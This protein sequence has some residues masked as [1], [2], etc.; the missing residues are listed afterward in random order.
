MSKAAVPLF[1][2]VIPTYNRAMR[3]ARTIDTVLAQS[4]ANFELLI[5]DD[6]S[7]DGTAE[8]VE[9]YRDSRIRYDWAPNS[10][11]PATPRN[12]GIDLAKGDWV[13][14]LDADDLWYPKKLEA[15]AEV[16]T[17]APEITAIC[18]N[19]YRKNDVTGERRLL[20]HGPYEEDFYRVML[21]QGNRVSTSAVVVRREFLNRNELRFNT[22]E[23]YAIVEDYDLWLRI[24]LTSGRFF[25]IE[26]PLGEYIIE[27]DN[28]TSNFKRYQHNRTCLLRDHVM[29]VQSFEPNR[30][31]LWR[32]MKV[33]LAI[34]NSK[35]IV[36][37]HGLIPAAKVVLCAAL[38]SPLSLAYYFFWW[39]RR[40]I[41]NIRIA[42]VVGV[43]GE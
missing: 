5:M 13:A 14:F 12:R 28:L 39:L 43:K 42:S 1:S 25:F 31:K 10:G 38:N 37:T 22:T 7:T 41:R 19:E 23:E 34:Q 4:F 35:Q 21:L 9:S 40:R 3:L 11:G 2:V 30:E 6:G 29:N 32:M 33:R 18:H 26:D 15:V 24:A 20:C 27:N 8:M 17:H 36:R 16:I